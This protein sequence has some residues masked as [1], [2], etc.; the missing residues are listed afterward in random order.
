MQRTVE[1]R[2]ARLQAPAGTVDTHIHFLLSEYPTRNPEAPRPA[3]ATI[4][5]YQVIR[6]RLGI[7]RAVIV[8]P[9][10]YGMDNRCTLRCL[11]RMGGAARAI[12]CVNSDTPDTELEWMHTLGVRGAL[13]FELPSGAVGLSDAVETE[14]R[15]RSLGWHLITQFDGRRIAEYLPYL[16]QLR[17]PYVIDHAGKF[18]EPVEA[19]S[20]EFLD[21]LRLVDRGN[22]YVK[23]SACYET[24][25]SGP[26]AYEDVGVLSRALIEHAPER[27]IWATNWPH[28]SATARTM[29]DD[30][31]L[32]DVLAGLGARHQSARTDSG[33]DSVA[34]L[35]FLR[36]LVLLYES[37]F[38]QRSRTFPNDQAAR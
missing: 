33:G 12:V 13:I 4:A 38:T 2:M 19:D 10:A 11:E 24:S 22:C 29:P 37:L 35:W 16:C 7:D 32:L 15:I 1:G 20:A 21:L 9:N 25:R 14:A 27:I 23:I 31:D 28:V 17:G 30:A 8:Q 5:E 3:D 34:P 6:R 36:C 18:L 26:P